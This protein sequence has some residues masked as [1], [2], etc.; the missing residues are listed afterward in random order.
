[1]TTALLAEP[2]ELAR[3]Y[4]FHGVGIAVTADRSDLLEAMHIRLRHFAV[5]RLPGAADLTFIF[6][7]SAR[8]TSHRKAEGRKQTRLRANSERR[9]CL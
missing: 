7:G 8:S 9:H 2:A 5:D 1:M 3:Y 4:N 6:Q